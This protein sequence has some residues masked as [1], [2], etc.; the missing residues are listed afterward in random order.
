MYH[1][2]Q[3]IRQRSAVGEGSGASGAVRVFLTSAYAD[4]E[5]LSGFLQMLKVHPP[6]RHR[7]VEDPAQA[8]VILFVENSHY[9]SDRYFQQLLR[10]S[11][12]RQYPRKVYMY[13]PHDT[14]WLVLPGI[15]PSIP[16]PLFDPHLFASGAFV[17]TINPY[18]ACDFSTPPPYLFSFF[19]SPYRGVRARVARL[20]H[21][22]AEIRAFA[23]NMYGD[24]SNKKTPQLQY[25]E[26]LTQSK[27]VLCP[28][29]IAASSIRVFEVMQAGRVP[30]II[31]DA[32]VPP[33]GPRW[34]D[35]AVVVREN[36]IEA[37]PRILEQEEGQ[38]EQKGRLAREEWEQYFAPGGVVLDYMIDSILKLDPPGS[39]Q[40]SLPGRL[41]H[42]RAKAAYRFRLLRHQVKVTLQKSLKSLKKKNS[43]MYI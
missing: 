32:W 29:G 25:A 5:P 3:S 10:H 39:Y 15:Y 7:L 23:Q 8:D 19:G 43:S 36:D 11:L 13:N 26:L 21:P 28:K 16:K 18:I 1:T 20:R 33:Q 27:F 22:K 12:V 42:Q 40:L 38:W 4:P 41:A 37:I 17:E 14:P 30:V 9:Y 31:S 6:G 2:T 24:R 35:F 34:E